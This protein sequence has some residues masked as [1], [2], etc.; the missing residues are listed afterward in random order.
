MQIGAGERVNTAISHPRTLASLA[1]QVAKFQKEI[2]IL[3]DSD[4]FGLE[5]RTATEV[6]QKN[7]FLRL[8]K[9]YGR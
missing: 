9:R 6:R 2:F 3:F 7:K 8:D 5:V 1:D 4:Q